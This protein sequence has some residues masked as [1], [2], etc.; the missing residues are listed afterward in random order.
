MYLTTLA[1][2][3]KRAQA[4]RFDADDVPA[5]PVDR[6]DDDDE[7]QCSDEDKPDAAVNVPAEDHSLN[8][9][10]AAMSM[11][12]SRT[13]TVLFDRDSGAM[14]DHEHEA[15][16]RRE[17]NSAFAGCLA[18]HVWTSEPESS[19]LMHQIAYLSNYEVIQVARLMNRTQYRMQQAFAENY[20][21]HERRTVYHGTSESGAPLIAS[22]GFK[23]AACRRALWGKGIY[24]SPNIWEALAYAPPHS[25]V[26][27]VIIVVQ[28]T[29]G[30]TAVGSP[31]QIDFGVDGDCSEVLTLTNPA[32]TIL[33]HA[34]ENQLLATHRITVRYMVEH[35]FVHRHRECIKFVHGDV[36][37]LIKRA[38]DEWVASQ[39]PASQPPASALPPTALPPSFSGG[40]P[41]TS[42][43]SPTVAAS[44]LASVSPRNPYVDTPHRDFSIGD[45]IVVTDTL[46]AFRDF[47]DMKGVICRIVKGHTYLLC[48]RL[49]KVHLRAIVVRLNANRENYIRS[50]FLDTDE[51]E[52]DLLLLTTGQ[53]RVTHKAI[54]PRETRGKRKRDAL[55]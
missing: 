19:Q 28:L 36:A 55:P 33:C 6:W 12:E 3:R 47:Q 1:R 16:L 43:V 11:L 42:G 23:G 17:L 45:K 39:S 13:E 40:L 2:D 53:V 34:K 10:Y 21:V 32:A 27:Q 46:K 8:S 7:A 15:E 30:P 9:M 37:E 50:S 35:N 54:P 25:N 31:N 49:D 20:N 18:N 4:L 29:Q 5:A 48:V 51:G 52:G 44:A 41:Q 26:R 38:R 14:P 24:T 22:V